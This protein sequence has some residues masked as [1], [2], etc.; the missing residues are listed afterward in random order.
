MVCGRV[1]FGKVLR[2]VWDGPCVCV[3]ALL[4][5]HLHRG[6]ASLK[7]AAL[8]A[9]FTTAAWR[10]R[11]G[12]YCGGTFSGILQKLDYIQGMGFDAIW[13]SPGRFGEREPFILLPPPPHLFF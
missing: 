9:H 7:V 8:H 5:E 13:I 6:T 12:N 1:V 4:V 2:V 3:P 11:Y 10:H